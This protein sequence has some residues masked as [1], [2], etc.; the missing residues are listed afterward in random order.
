[1]SLL[2]HHDE[3]AFDPLRLGQRSLVTKAVFVLAGTLILALAS[4]ISVPMVPVPI[5]MQTF[6]ITMIG[7]LYGWRL[8]AITVFAWLGEAAI[9]FPVLAGGAGGVAPFV[10]PTAG[11]LVSF[12][13]IAAL[14][15]WL[16]ER[17]WSG[18]RVVRSFLA[19]FSANILCLAIGGAWLAALIGAEKGWLLGVAPFIL[20]AVLK[21][22]LAAAVLKI[23]QVYSGKARLN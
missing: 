6:A 1:M 18:N 17:G 11:Y 5:T 3:V 2:Q 13:I 20:G 12:P 10:G 9:G 15:G 14:V 23:I 7:A 4:R 8:G 22:A 21:S 16:A 19:H